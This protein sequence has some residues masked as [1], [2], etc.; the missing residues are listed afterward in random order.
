[1]I[2]SIL[3]VVAFNV[4]AGAQTVEDSASVYEFVE[5]YQHTINTHDPAALAAFFTDDADLMMFNLP[6]VLVAGCLAE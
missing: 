3:I 2:T 6:E 1:M 5:E 4:I